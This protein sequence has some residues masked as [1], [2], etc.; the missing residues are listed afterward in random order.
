MYQ[1]RSTQRIAN[2]NRLGMISLIGFSTALFLL[3]LIETL[4]PLL[5]TP[6]P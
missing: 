6:T 3:L 1:G 2:N 4:S 5:I